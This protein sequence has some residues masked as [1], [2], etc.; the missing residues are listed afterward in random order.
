MKDIR[1]C[2]CSQ[3]KLAASWTR[4]GY[5]VYI[6]PWYCLASMSDT[7]RKLEEETEDGSEDEWIGPRP[8]EAAP[9]PKI[10]K[11]KGKE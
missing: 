10:K 5:S 9:E 3:E 8:E 6:A 11:I 2:D 1:K 4:E 7:K